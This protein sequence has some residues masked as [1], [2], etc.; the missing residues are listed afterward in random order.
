MQFYATFYIVIFV[1][2][3]YVRDFYFDKTYTFFAIG[4]TWIPQIVHNAVYKNRLS[5]PLL[6]IFI[7]TIN[8]IFVPLYYRTFKGNFLKFESD[9]SF[10]FL[11]I[12]F[13][14]ITVN[15]KILNFLDWFNVFPKYIWTKMVFTSKI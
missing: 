13:H 9:Y 7:T 15:H 10:T 3:F 11:T 12:G 1:S 6:Y 14:F 5:F 8:K 4:M 2:L